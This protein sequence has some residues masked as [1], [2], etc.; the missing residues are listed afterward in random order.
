GHDR[1]LWLSLKAE[2]AERHEK[3]LEQPLPKFYAFDADW[4]AVKATRENIIAAG[5]EKLL[6]QIQ[7]EERTLADWPDF[8]DEK[9]TAFIVTNPPYGER[10]GDK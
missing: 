5:F 9:K 6:S 3:A 7:I 1:E 2:A 8:A 4:E 10:L